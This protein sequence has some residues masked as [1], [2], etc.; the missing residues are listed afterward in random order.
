MQNEMT[1]CFKH[2]FQVN[3]GTE[4]YKGLAS[5]MKAHETSSLSNLKSLEEEPVSPRQPSKGY[6]LTLTLVTD[7]EPRLNTF[8]AAGKSDIRDQEKSSD[9]DTDRLRVRMRKH[10]TSPM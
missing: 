1:P 7:D 10:T 8:R 3:G 5:K 9:G 4:T 6:H 2:S